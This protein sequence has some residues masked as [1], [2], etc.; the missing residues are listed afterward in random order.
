MLKVLKRFLAPLAA[1]AFIGLLPAAAY[2]DSVSYHTVV[3]FTGAGTN[4]SLGTG[5]S[6]V[7]GLG[8]AGS[9]KLVGNA[10]VAGGDVVEAFG[11]GFGDGYAYD[12]IELDPDA[13]TSATAFGQFKMTG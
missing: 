12:A 13:S 6:A 2:A 3:Y 10:G 4:S 9:T 11:L 7:T 8:G 5:G 1:V